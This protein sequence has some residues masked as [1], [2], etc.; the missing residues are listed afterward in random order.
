MQESGL[1]AQLDAGAKNNMSFRASPK[2]GVGI[3]RLEEK[4]LPYSSKM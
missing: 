4:T 1:I 2:T 3:P